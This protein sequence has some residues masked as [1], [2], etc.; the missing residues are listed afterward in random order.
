MKNLLSHRENE[1]NAEVMLSSFVILEGFREEF[2]VKALKARQ[3]RK[4]PA[5]SMVSHFT[6][7]MLGVIASLRVG[8]KAMSSCEIIKMYKR[9]M[10][11]VFQS[12]VSLAKV[13]LAKVLLAKVLFIKGI[14]HVNFHKISLPLLLLKFHL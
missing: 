4:D 11:E 13:S 7:G 5:Y 10:Y 2:S 8:F 6:G 14:V 9:A 3:M 1:P 12:K